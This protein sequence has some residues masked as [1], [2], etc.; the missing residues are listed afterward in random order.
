MTASHLNGTPLYDCTGSMVIYR[1]PPE[2]IREAAESFLNSDCSVHL[3]VVDN[4]PSAALRSAFDGLAVAYH[5]YGENVGYGRGHNWAIFHAGPSRYHLVFNPDIRIPAG[6]LCSM[7]RFMEDHPDAGMVCPRV[8]NEDGSDQYLNKRYPSVMDFFVRRFVPSFLT[9]LFKRRLDR[10][11]MRDVGY[12]KVCDVEV[13]TGAFM[14]CRTG[15]LKKLA[16]FDPRYFL[17]FEDYDLSRKF[18]KAG[19][20]TLYDPGAAVIH[21]WTRGSHKHI[22]MTMIFAVNMCRYYNKWGWTWL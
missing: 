7:I 14:L 10:Y 6:T 5:H 21:H 1:N 4:S 12:D 8:L 11:E 3:T 15:I 2:I 16:G 18:Q 13:M 22:G 19:F 20:R 17:Y 9:P